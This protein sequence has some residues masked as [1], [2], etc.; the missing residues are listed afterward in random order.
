MDIF[1]KCIKTGTPFTIK[2][3]FSGNRRYLVIPMSYDI[4]SDVTLKL[5]EQPV[6]RKTGSAKIN[7]FIV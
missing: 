4:L 2:G 7:L 3:E 5:T 1:R 6:M